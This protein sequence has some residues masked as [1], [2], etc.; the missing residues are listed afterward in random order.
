MKEAR[1][2]R[3][4]YRVVVP[5]RS[6]KPTDRGKGESS[7]GEHVLWSWQGWNRI[8]IFCTISQL[9]TVHRVHKS[10]SSVVRMII[11]HE[12][13]LSPLLLLLLTSLP[14]LPLPSPHTPH[15][16]PTHHHHHPFLS[17]LAQVRSPAELEYHA[18]KAT[19]SKCTFFTGVAQVSL[20][21]L[22][23][24][25]CLVFSVVTSGAVSGCLLT[26]CL[27]P[28]A[29]MESGKMEDHFFVAVLVLSKFGNLA[30][31]SLQ[32][33]SWFAGSVAE[34]SGALLMMPKFGN[35]S[36]PSLEGESVFTSSLVEP[37]IAFRVMICVTAATICCS[38][39][40]CPWI[41][42]VPGP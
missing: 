15:H 26:F 29:S 33:E 6:D 9:V 35:L 18:A 42:P 37:V 1:V 2:A 22:M 28:D 38:W 20:S 40:V 41:L 21:C 19:I 11:E 8:Q 7:G 5:I 17:I 31:P 24:R 4:F 13:V 32:G 10:V 16:H 34:P 39:W 23:S 25:L 27:H 12:I 30:T 36:A 14:P 3:G